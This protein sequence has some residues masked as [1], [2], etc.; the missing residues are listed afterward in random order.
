MTKSPKVDPFLVRCDPRTKLVAFFLLAPLLLTRPVTTP[1][2]WVAI[3]VVLVATV[4]AKMDLSYLFRQLW[5]LKWL[6]IVLVVFH[7]VLTPG[8][9]LWPA[10][11]GISREGLLAGLVYSTRLILMVC[12]AW[13]LIQTTPATQ[14]VAG[15]G[16]L[17]GFLD[18]I[19]PWHRG[20]S[21]LAYTLGRIP[22]LLHEA[23][24]IKDDLA[25]RLGHPGQQGVV[26][27]LHRMALAGEALLFRLL[28]SAHAQEEALRLRGISHGL[29]PLP[30]LASRLGWRDGAVLLFSVLA[31]AVG[32]L[33]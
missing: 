18:Q 22:L 15:L 4:A 2:G 29:L 12:L 19:V 28:H 1:G 13:I 25:C 31:V 26:Q 27:R 7:G 10:V 6:F 11:Q 32:V 5:R 30:P 16:R 17:L 3:L 23:G 8:E 14:L 24:R 9:P 21:L 20:L 33:V